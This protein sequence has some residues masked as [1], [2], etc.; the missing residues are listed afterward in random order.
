MYIYNTA[1]I[2]IY[3]YTYLYYVSIY[4]ILNQN[5]T[6]SLQY[7]TLLLPDPRAAGVALYKFYMYTKLFIISNLRETFANKN[8][9]FAN[10]KIK[11]VARVPNIT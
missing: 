2:Y 8:V 1:C 5:Q 7:N 9:T 10:S 6:E 11:P 3:R 4:I